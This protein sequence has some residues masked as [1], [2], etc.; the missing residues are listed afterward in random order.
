[1]AHL[2]PT[3]NHDSSEPTSNHDSSEPH[4]RSRPIKPR[5]HLGPRQAHL[6]AQPTTLNP[7]TQR[8]RLSTQ[9]SKP[10]HQAGPSPRAHGSPAGAPDVRPLYPKPSPKNPPHPQHTCL[11]R[12]APTSVHVPAPAAAPPAVGSGGGGGTQRSRT[13]WRPRTRGGRYKRP[14]RR[15]D[16]AARRYSAGDRC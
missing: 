15:L 4:Q 8:A 13:T 7:I 2:N 11:S 1:M 3:S 6:G 9:P 16:T 10:H 5:H 14:Q 12:R